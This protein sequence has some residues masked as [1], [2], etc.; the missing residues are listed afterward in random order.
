M[1]SSVRL[2]GVDQNDDVFVVGLAQESDGVGAALL[3]QIPVDADLIEDTDTYCTTDDRHA[4]VY[5]GVRSVTID[6]AELHLGWSLEAA[7]VLG[8]GETTSLELMVPGSQVQALRAGLRR[9]FTYGV[10]SEHPELNL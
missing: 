2:V 5:G 10:A 9:V 1:I 7:E 4:T 8:S 3:F 6:G